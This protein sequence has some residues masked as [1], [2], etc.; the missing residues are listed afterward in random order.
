MNIHI[1]SSKILANEI[2]QH[3]KRITY[4]DQARFIP[5]MQ[6]WLNI[7]KAIDLIQ[8]GKFLNMVKA[9]YEKSTA[10]V[11]LRCERLQAYPLKSGAWQWCP[12]SPLL[13][14]IV[15]YVPAKAM[16]QANSSKA[17]DFRNA[18]GEGKLSQFTDD[19]V[20]T[21]A[22]LNIRK[23]VKANKWIHQGY[24]TLEQTQTSV[25]FLYLAINNLKR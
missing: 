2:Q 20:F 19:M 17:K 6:G 1:K 4:H 3:I 21:Y 12:L 13:L 11:I 14:N 9:I 15:R 16:R 7:Q 23:A 22:I 24:R 18:Q 25:V 5:E 10:N 8:E